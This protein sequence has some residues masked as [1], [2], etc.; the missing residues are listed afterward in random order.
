MEQ[1]I[2]EEYQGAVDENLV[3]FVETSIANKGSNKGRYNLKPVSE[4]AAQ[5]IKAITGIDAAGFKT[6]ME[7]RIAEHI[8]N[9]H[10]PD[11]T[12]DRSMA[13]LNDV[14]RIQY[15]LDNYD[16]VNYGGRTGS[17]STNKANGY[18]RQADTVVFE[19]A[20]NGTYY[21]VEAVPDT[22]KKT[23]YI[24]SAY[25]SRNSKNK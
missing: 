16:S 24:V 5:D 23:T 25:M 15:V 1:A 21:V 14:G 10:G 17:Y 22:S 7:Q 11:G 6:V 19:K 18:T 2:I 20:V 8:Y 13:D 12:T 9:E 3:N 4:R